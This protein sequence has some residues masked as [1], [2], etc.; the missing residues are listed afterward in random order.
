M[1]LEKQLEFFSIYMMAAPTRYCSFHASVS[2]IPNATKTPSGSF[3]FFS[4]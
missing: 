3:F 1:L 2:K 4:L